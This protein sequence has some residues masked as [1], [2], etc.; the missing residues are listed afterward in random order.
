MQNLFNCQN[1]RRFGAEIELNTLDGKI[2]KLNSLNGENPT[3]IE[4]IALL[5]K[6]CLKKSVE[7]QAWNYNFNNNYWIVKPDSS[8]GIEVC[9]PVLKGWF[10]L[11]DLIDVVELFRCK[12]ISADDRCSFHVHVDISDLNE[13]QLASVI[14]WYIKCEHIFM[15]SVPAKRKINRYC[16]MLGLTDLFNTDYVIEPMKIIQDVSRVKYYTLNTYHFIKGGGFLDNNR[17]KTIEF[18]IAENQMCLS[19]Y[20]VKNWIRLLLHFIEVTKNK[21]IPKNYIKNEKWTGLLWLDP[22]DVFDLLFNHSISA[23]LLQ[24]RD[25]FINR[26]LTNAFNSNLPGIWSNNIRKNVY[27]NFINYLDKT[28]NFKIEKKEILDLIYNEKY[29]I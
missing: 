27:K 6:N 19:G 15:D 10:G 21:D 29:I 1:F 20:D 24:V 14:S 28:N 16:Q 5:I 11:K 22:E 26:I 18:R 8:C 2:K 7:I 9:T 17:K 3:G 23:G 4:N 25:W 12:K 13:Y